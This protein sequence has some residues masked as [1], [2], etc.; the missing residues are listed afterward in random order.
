MAPMCPEHSWENVEQCRRGEDG[1]MILVSKVRYRRGEGVFE[2]VED[3]VNVCEA[4]GNVE[5]VVNGQVV[6]NQD[7]SSWR[8]GSGAHGQVSE[9][10]CAACEELRK[11]VDCDRMGIPLPP[12]FPFLPPPPGGSIPSPPPAPSSAG[13]IPPPPPPA[14]PFLPPGLQ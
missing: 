9:M 5:V 3:A 6:R 2:Y 14:W 8:Q 10:T 12:G 11:P 13:I 1:R 4:L 7:D